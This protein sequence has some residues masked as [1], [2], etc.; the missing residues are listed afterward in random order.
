MKN[1]WIIEFLDADSHLNPK[2]LFEQRRSINMELIF[3]FTDVIGKKQA[4]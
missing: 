3:A 4:Y 2:N 1:K